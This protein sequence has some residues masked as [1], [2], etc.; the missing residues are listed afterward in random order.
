MYPKCQRSTYLAQSVLIATFV[1]TFQGTK[2]HVHTFWEPKKLFANFVWT[3]G[4]LMH[5]FF[6]QDLTSCT[7]F[8]AVFQRSRGMGITTWSTRMGRLGTM[9]IFLESVH[10]L[11]TFCT[12]SFQVPDSWSRKALHQ[13][14]LLGKKCAK[15]VYFQHQGHLPGP[16]R[17]AAA[18]WPAYTLTGAER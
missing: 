6:C 17:S 16:L 10:F 9:N 18:S 13:P 4:H 15:C 7:L 1:Q 5:A 2:Q 3:A 8:Q 12:L 14:D 11:C